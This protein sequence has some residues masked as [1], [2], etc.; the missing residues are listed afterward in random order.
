M[1]ILT[2]LLLTTTLWAEAMASCPNDGPCASYTVWSALAGGCTGTPT[3]STEP[4]TSCVSDT[5]AASW[6]TCNSD[7]T[8]VTYWLD[9]TCANAGSGMDQPS[10]TCYYDDTSNPGSPIY[11]MW[12]CLNVDPPTTSSASSLR[13]TKTIVQSM[14]R[15][16][17]CLLGPTI[18]EEMER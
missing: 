9:K 17:D 4:G 3:A 6:A 13:Y 18:C 7:D 15:M 16:L 5:Q 2:C 8:V 11:A 10:G 12:E 14:G 1:L